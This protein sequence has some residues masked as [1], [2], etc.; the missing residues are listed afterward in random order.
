MQTEYDYSDLS[1]E[2]ILEHK[3][4]EKE[5]AEQEKRDIREKWKKAKRFSGW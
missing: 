5:K 3:E 4:R 2:E 1:D